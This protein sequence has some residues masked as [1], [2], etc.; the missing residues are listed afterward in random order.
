MYLCIY[1]LTLP[2]FSFFFLAKQQLISF[3][4]LTNILIGFLSSSYSVYYWSGS[5]EE[6]KEKKKEREKEREREGLLGI[7]DVHRVDR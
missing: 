2:A 4:P 1:F 6:Q 7:E 3:F 5:A